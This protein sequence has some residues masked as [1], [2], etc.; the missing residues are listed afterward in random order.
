MISD[1]GFQLIDL[2]DQF[3]GVTLMHLQ[4][5]FREAQALFGLLELFQNA[6]CG[7]IAPVNQCLIRFG[8][9]L[10]GFIPQHIDL[11]LKRIFMVKGIVDALAQV[12]HLPLKIR[13][14]FE[15]R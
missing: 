14:A 1:G 9:Q 13:C 12:I 11:C 2:Q 8:V 3:G 4:V 15:A 7:I 5:G 6:P 10:G